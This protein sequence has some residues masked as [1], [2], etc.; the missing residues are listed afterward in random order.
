MSFFTFAKF[1]PDKTINCKAWVAIKRA[2]RDKTV[3]ASGDK[4]VWCLL[5]VYPNKTESKGGKSFKVTRAR[6]NNP[7]NKRKV[8]VWRAV[9]IYDNYTYLQ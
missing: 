7:E 2:M 1:N 8:D 9:Y 5:L 6:H 4:I 3:I